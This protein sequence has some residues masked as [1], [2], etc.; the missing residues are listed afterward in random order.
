MTQQSAQIAFI[1]CSNERSLKQ[2]H[3]AGKNDEIRP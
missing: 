2:I 1:P 3:T